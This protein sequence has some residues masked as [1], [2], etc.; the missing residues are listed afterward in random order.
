MGEP[1]GLLSVGLHRVGHDWSD[2]AA[3]AAA[4]TE[5]LQGKLYFFFLVIIYLAV[6][7]L[8]CSMWDPV[9]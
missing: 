6:P 1:S 8:G 5:C 4:S 2:L 9:P 3:A 7:G